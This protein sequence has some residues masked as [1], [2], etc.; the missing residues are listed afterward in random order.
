MTYSICPATTRHCSRHQ[1]S[2]HRRISADTHGLLRDLLPTCNRRLPRQLTLESRGQ[3]ALGRNIS[4]DQPSRTTANIPTGTSCPLSLSPLQLLSIRQ[5]QP[6]H[7]HSPLRPP[8]SRKE[9]HPHSPGSQPTQTL[10]LPLALGVGHGAG[11][12]PHTVY[13]RRTLSPIF[14]AVA[15]TRSPAPERVAQRMQVCRFQ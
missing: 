4:N 9:T 3:R 2:P 14:R 6:Q 11:Q 5:R 10:A 1:E 12:I 13:T 7:S 15:P 8:L